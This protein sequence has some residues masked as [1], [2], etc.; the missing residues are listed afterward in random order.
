MMIQK[1]R[2]FPAYQTPRVV[3]FQL[4]SEDCIASSTNTNE[5]LGEEDDFMDGNTESFT[6]GN[7]I[8]KW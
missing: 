6:E 8:I 7:S 1:N 4:L 2:F 5:G 3:A